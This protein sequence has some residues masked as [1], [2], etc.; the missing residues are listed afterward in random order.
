MSATGTLTS[1]KHGAIG[2]VEAGKGKVTR[3]A[4]GRPTRFEFKTKFDRVPNV[5]ITPVFPDKNAG[6]R[7]FW[8]YLLPKDAGTN[9][10]D[11]S[12]FY[13]GMFGNPGESYEFEYLAVAIYTAGGV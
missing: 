7:N 8:F 9:P 13:L 4:D 10:V 1:V 2:E 5:Q 12:G 11:E 3:Y 6:F